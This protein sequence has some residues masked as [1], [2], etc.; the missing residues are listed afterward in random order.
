M[1][2]SKVLG[3][4][5]SEPQLRFYFE[6]LK[7]RPELKEKF[8]IF[9]FLSTFA[10]PVEI[11]S[12]KKGGDSDEDE[13][14]GEMQGYK[15][16]DKLQMDLEERFAR[17]PQPIEFKFS[18]N[19]GNCCKQCKLF[20]GFHNIDDEALK[21]YFD[22]MLIYGEMKPYDFT[23]I[24]S[25]S[26]VQLFFTLFLDISQIDNTKKIVSKVSRILVNK[27]I[28]MRVKTA[29]LLFLGHSLN[30]NKPLYRMF[31]ATDF[32]IFLQDSLAEFL[33]N[34]GLLSFKYAM[35][36]KFEGDTNV[37]FIRGKRKLEVEPIFKGL[38]KRK[39]TVINLGRHGD[40]SPLEDVINFK[41]KVIYKDCVWDDENLRF[42][43]FKVV[44]TPR[45]WEK[46]LEY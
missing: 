33:Q 34:F 42:S 19:C 12:K 21:V 37:D 1:L 23:N 28:D 17:R 45:I 14:F 9:P 7:V 5:E 35:K 36:D 24:E 4:N 30:I 3:D 25:F 10:K 16:P 31:I 46:I 15:S 41:K 18:E 13:L 22:S 44:L 27:K 38:Q 29:F 11:K 43:Y 6:E 26:L 39:A 2:K 20:G 8:T 32:N 40:Q